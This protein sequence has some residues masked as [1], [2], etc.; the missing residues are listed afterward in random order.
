[1]PSHNGDAWKAKFA[2]NKARDQAV[3]AALLDLGLKVVTIWE[4]DSKDP[5]RLKK[6][7]STHLG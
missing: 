7:L 1:M 5:E 6:S 4:C 2:A 3:N